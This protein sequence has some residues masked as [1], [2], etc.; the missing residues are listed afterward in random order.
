MSIGVFLILLLLFAGLEGMSGVMWRLLSVLSQHA[1]LAGERG[2]VVFML[3]LIGGSGGPSMLPIPLG[4]V[5]LVRE[6][7]VWG[8]R[9]IA[10]LYV[11]SNG[12]RYRAM[13][14]DGIHYSSY[15]ISRSVSENIEELKVKR[16]YPQV[17]AVLIV[18]G[19][20]EARTPLGYWVVKTAAAPQR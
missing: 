9:K 18:Y 10:N 16:V 6:I 7:Y 19:D 3:S 8:P 5:H 2:I 14:M 20:G 12:A 4:S 15:E 17:I 11:E 1:Q 13:D